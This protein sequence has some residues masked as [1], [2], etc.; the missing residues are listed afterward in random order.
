MEN[1]TYYKQIVEEVRKTSLEK[2]KELIQE[3]LYLYIDNL[4]QRE[5]Y[6][7]RK[8]GKMNRSDVLVCDKCDNNLT[9]NFVR[10]GTYERALMVSEGYISKLKVPRVKCACC[11]KKIKG[12]NGIIKKHSRLWHDTQLLVTELFS[13]KASIR[14][15]KDAMRRRN[16]ES[17]G[18]GTILNSI[19][20]IKPTKIDIKDFPREVGLDGFWGRGKSVGIR[21]KN[22]GLLA[23]DQNPKSRNRIL[24]WKLCDSENYKYWNQMAEYLDEKLN[25]NHK[26]GLI[27]YVSDGQKGILKSISG[28]TE[29]NTICSFHILGNIKQNMANVSNATTFKLMADAKWI[30]KQKSYENAENVL[31]MIE[32]KWEG[33]YP[34]VFKNLKKSLKATKDFWNNKHNLTQTNNRTERIIKEFKRKIKQMEGLRSKETAESVMELL[35]MRINNRDDWFKKLEARIVA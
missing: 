17:L 19:R 30:F 21:Q 9:S 3:Y 33:K 14:E 18:T 12:I 7:H 22:I 25:I 10:N 15:I 13:L 20:S 27:N 35:T 24:A 16:N 8:H 32:K 26:T 28:R 29:F 31:K 11:G 1:I 2:K 23:V 4:I 6:L 34:K 5:K